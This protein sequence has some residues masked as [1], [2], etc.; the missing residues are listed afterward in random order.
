MNATQKTIMNANLFSR[1]F[2]GLDNNA[3]SPSNQG[4]S[5]Q[6]VQASPDAVAEFRVITSNFNAEYGRV[7]GGVVSAAMRAGT[8]QLHG[9]AYEFF[10]NTDLNAVGFFAPTGG[11]KPTLQRNQFGFT[12]GGPFIKNKLFFFADYEG[13]RQ[14][15]RYLN[16]DSI[17]TL[18]D[19]SGV[20]PSAVY[21]PLTGTVYAAG[22]TIPVSQ[23]NPFAATVL[24]NLPAPNVGAATSRSNNYEALLLIRDFSDKFDAKIDYQLNSSMSA[25]LRFDQ[26]KDLPYYQPDLPGPSGGNG[27][28]NIHA[29]QQQ[30]A[31]GSQSSGRVVQS[32]GL[33]AECHRDLRLVGPECTDRSRDVE[34]R[35]RAVQADAVGSTLPALRAV[36][37]L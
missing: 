31:A 32:G 34:R 1:L 12:A 15:Q 2:D 9:T 13:Y 30:A 16:F 10:R 20:F 29:I 7:G 25:F 27:N 35:R 19:R 37:G 23:L 18:A 3:Y 11:R 14:L 28:G 22:S 21:N 17:P 4:Y 6:V 26:R 33:H 8:N 36:P 5:S 24:G